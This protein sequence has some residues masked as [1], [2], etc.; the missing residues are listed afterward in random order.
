MRLVLSLTL[1]LSFS[2]FQSTIAASSLDVTASTQLRLLELKYFEHTFDNEPAEERVDRVERLVRGDVTEG[3]A[4]DRVKS[5]AAM[6]QAEGESLSPPSTASTDS[7]TASNNTA[8]SKSADPN[9]NTGNSNTTA[10][11]NAGDMGDYP[12][13]DN[14]EKEILGKKFDGQALPERLAQLEK[15]AFGAVT[16]STDYG[17]RT[18]KLEDY[19]ERVLHDKPFAVNPDIDK[20]YIIPASRPSNR[21][22]PISGY[23]FPGTPS[24]YSPAGY[25]APS[26]F[27][28]NDNNPNVAR[29]GE[30]QALEH[31]FGGQRRQD[32]YF[33]PSTPT[34]TDISQQDDPEVYQKQ[35]PDSDARMITRVGWCE[36]Q[37][38]GHTFPQMHLTKR[39]RQLSDLV[40]PKDSKQTDMQLMDDLDP[41]M[42]AVI[43]KKGEQQSISGNS[44]AH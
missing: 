28:N 22:A 10:A 43:A 36:V 2:F 3:T 5:I 13:V 23:Q 42:K 19:A 8:K 21:P 34:G 30:Q 1:A 27:G 15:K 35:P 7:S 32:Q 6:L 9:S 25:P 24:Y 37:L 26:S 14:L 33:S 44:Q 39:L 31:F 29:L 4:Q 16:F 17:G 20:A 40:L 11:G 18:D 41:I 12:K 38:F